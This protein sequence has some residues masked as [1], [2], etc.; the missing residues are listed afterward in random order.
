M[1][2]G[3]KWATS[4]TAGTVTITWQNPLRTDKN[5]RQYQ[6]ESLSRQA[7]IPDNC[8]ALYERPTVS[9]KAPVMSLCV[10]V[11]LRSRTGS[12][13][14][15]NAPVSTSNA[16]VSFDGQN[17][18]GSKGSPH[19]CGTTRRLGH[20]NTKAHQMIARYKLWIDAKANNKVSSIILS[21]TMPR[22]ITYAAKHSQRW[23]RSS[24]CSPPQRYELSV[25]VWGVSS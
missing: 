18:G 7:T 23:A 25:D 19:T 21:T 24:A 12:G 6:N 15:C 20:L 3:C 5:R 11:Y 9:N 10:S 14:R 4:A 17:E 22:H 1:Y 8:G 13:A 2:A 16:T